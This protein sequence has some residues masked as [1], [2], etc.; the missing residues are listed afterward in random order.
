[1]IITSSVLVM[2]LMGSGTEQAVGGPT[3]N[4]CTGG[5]EGGQ[6]IVQSDTRDSMSRFKETTANSCISNGGRAVIMPDL[7]D[8]SLPQERLT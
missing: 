8:P 6:L 2:A 7:P 4:F 3:G 1:M 5:L